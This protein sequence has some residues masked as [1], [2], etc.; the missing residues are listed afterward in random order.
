MN[1]LT[2]EINL[3]PEHRVYDMVITCV[4]VSTRLI[5]A[6]CLFLKSAN[7]KKRFYVKKTTVLF[8]RQPLLDPRPS[9]LNGAG[10]ARQTRPAHSGTSFH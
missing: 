5:S 3:K 7:K 4:R 2:L 1:H 8:Q 9:D 6:S 10:S